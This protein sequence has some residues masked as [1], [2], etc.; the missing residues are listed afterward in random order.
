MSVSSR[1]GRIPLGRE[2]RGESYHVEIDITRGA[3]DKI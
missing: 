2:G 1:L 3:Y